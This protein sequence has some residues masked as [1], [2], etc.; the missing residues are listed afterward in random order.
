M[1]PFEPKTDSKEFEVALPE[2]MVPGTGS[3]A[4]LPADITIRLWRQDPNG[5][6][7]A[8]TWNSESVLVYMI[9]DLIAASQGHTA[10]E[11]PAVMSAHFASCNHA[12]VAAKRI[13]LAILEFVSCKAGDY[14]GA[15]VLVHPPVAAGFTS[16]MAQSALRL[17]EPGQI[18]LSEAVSRV[19]QDLPGIELRPV[20]ALTTGGSEHAGLSELLWASSE[21][22]EKIRE[23]ARAS[24]N[25]VSTTSQVG[26]TMIVNAPA[27][28]IHNPIASDGA[29]TGKQKLTPNP[30]TEGFVPSREGI[31]ED[32]LAEFQERRSFI[33]T[34]RVIIGVVA[35]VLIGAAVALFYPQHGSKLPRRP[36]ETQIEETQTT[37]SVT[38]PSTTPPEPAK[39][40]T[41]PDLHPKPVP[42]SV[43]RAPKP[44][45]AKDQVK[46]KE[47]AKKPEETPIQGFEGNSTYDGMTQRDIPRLLQWARSD[48][49]NG[50]YEKAGQ[51]YRVILQ[52]QPNN[53]DAK[54]G[55][56]K[57]QLAQGRDE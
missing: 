43:Q 16:G 27:M 53:P 20:A 39:V 17:S 8:L 2:R 44:P 31:F 23:S 3:A 26:A 57:I 1:A 6:S 37:P 19:A 22:I 14:L 5:S 7:P 38:Q 54:E 24:S 35:V 41:P 47:T 30:L 33:T 40:Q 28:G 25:R 49:G 10:S 51:E 56:R 11:M 4:T 55:L 21:Q 9:A 50:R 32:G 29:G 45:A 36:A 52:L 34:T 42:T 13:Q 18:I 12:F 15:A 46:E 48:A